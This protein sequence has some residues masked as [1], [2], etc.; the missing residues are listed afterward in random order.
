MP[1]AT[2]E[3]LAAL[4]E[5]TRLRV[6]SRALGIQEW[7]VAANGLAKDGVTIDAVNFVGAV[8]AGTVSRADG[9]LIQVGDLFEHSGL[10]Q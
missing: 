6:N 1:V 9:P 3:E 7:V 10:D 4:P 5:G 2:M 8:A